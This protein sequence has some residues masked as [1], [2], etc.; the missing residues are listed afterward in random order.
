[1]IVHL[2]MTG[3]LSLVNRNEPTAVHD[4]LRLLLDNGT[5]LRFNDARRFGSITVWPPAE[6]E[7][8]EKAFTAQT[9]IEPLGKKFTAVRL[10]E[11]ARSKKQPVKHFLM[12]ARVVAGLGNIYANEILFAAAVHPLT[13][14]NHITSVQWALIARATRRILKEAIQAGGSTISDF[15]GTSGNPGYFQV[16]FN[17]YQRRDEQ[18][19]RCSAVICKTVTAGR[20]TYFCPACQQLPEERIL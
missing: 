5:E 16:R 15:L 3:K 9:G 11:L 8:L 7:P 19:K 10:S 13:P 17:V 6:A 1:M 18:C 4:H 20:A 14:V 12:D 2:G